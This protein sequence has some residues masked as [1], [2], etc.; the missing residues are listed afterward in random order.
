LYQ[1]TRRH[2]VEKKHVFVELNVSFF[3]AQ[4][5]R[6]RHRCNAIVCGYQR[7]W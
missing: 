3:A 4:T 1:K 7:S 6:L 5:L 2:V